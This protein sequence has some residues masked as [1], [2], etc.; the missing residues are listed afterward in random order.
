MPLSPRDYTRAHGDRGR[1]CQHG[2]RECMVGAEMESQREDAVAT[3]LGV[4]QESVQLRN[5][6]ADL[7]EPERGERTDAQRQRREH[8]PSQRAVASG[9]QQ[10]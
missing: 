3:S 5:V 8:G 4:S 9:C 2:I 1:R 6:L 7:A 10:P